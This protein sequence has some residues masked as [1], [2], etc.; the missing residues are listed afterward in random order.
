MNLIM[1][2][3]FKV[4]QLV[5]WSVCTQKSYFLPNSSLASVLIHASHKEGTAQFRLTIGQDICQA[6]FERM[7]KASYVQGRYHLLTSATF[8]F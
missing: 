6:V 8:Q 3:E 4:D 2:G 1:S 5:K 7:I